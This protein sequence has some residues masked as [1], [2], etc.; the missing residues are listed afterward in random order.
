[1]GSC[2]EPYYTLWDQGP[3]RGLWL[4][5]CKVPEA[6]LEWSP[7]AQSGN[8]AKQQVQDA[9]AS[10]AQRIR[11]HTGGSE[12]CQETKSDYAIPGLRTLMAF[13]FPGAHRTFE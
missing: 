6:V 5:D 9:R 4:W 11:G 3:G 1:M 7:P 2:D 8:V 10:E 12:T 13:H